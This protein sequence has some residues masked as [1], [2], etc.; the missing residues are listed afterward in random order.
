MQSLKQGSHKKVAQCQ[1]QPC[2]WS[3]APR[4]GHCP[5]KQRNAAGNSWT[6]TSKRQFA[7]MFSFIS[8]IWFSTVSFC[9]AYGGIWEFLELSEFVW[10]FLTTLF[11][12]KVF[13]ETG[14]AA[15]IFFFLSLSL[16]LVN[17]HERFNLFK[18]RLLKN[19]QE[20]KNRNQNN[21]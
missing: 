3:K 17:F 1:W 19:S 21:L 15:A 16:N 13:V 12:Q 2:C 7:G 10:V 14:L 11:K 8:R 6:R 4:A 9:A 20:K 18:I 5:A